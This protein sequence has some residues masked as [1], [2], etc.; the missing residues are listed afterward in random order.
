MVLLSV[1]VVVQPHH[2]LPQLI[3]KA[4]AHMNEEMVEV[5][6]E[7]PN[8][9]ILALALKAHELDITLN[10]LINDILRRAATEEIKKAEESD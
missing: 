2:L 4:S 1:K 9:V 5:E 10:Q 7:L 8:D 3:L 6:L